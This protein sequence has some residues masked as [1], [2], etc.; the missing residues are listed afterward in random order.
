MGYR[1]AVKFGLFAV[2]PTSDRFERSQYAIKPDH[3]KLKRKRR[4]AKVM[5]RV[6]SRA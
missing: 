4:M 3:L 1:A 5:I 2:F 6:R